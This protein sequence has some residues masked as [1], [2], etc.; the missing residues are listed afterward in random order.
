MS[1]SDIKKVINALEYINNTDDMAQVINHIGIEMRKLAQSFH[2]NED[3]RWKLAKSASEYLGWASHE[4][5]KIKS[6]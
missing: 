1:N 3:D 5:Y 2:E 6:A 4:V